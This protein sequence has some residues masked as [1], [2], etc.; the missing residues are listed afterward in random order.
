MAT[1]APHPTDDLNV[2]PKVTEV[3]FSIRISHPQR[4][5][6]QIKAELTQTA[7]SWLRS[8]EQRAELSSIFLTMLNRRYRLRQG[9]KVYL[10]NYRESNGSLLISFSVLIIGF[11]SNYGGLQDSIERFAAD[12]D[13]FFDYMGPDYE[14]IIEHTRIT[15]FQDDTNGVIVRDD[16]FRNLEDRYS[17]SDLSKQVK[18]VRTLVVIMALLLLAV[19]TALT[20]FLT[21]QG[22]ALKADNVKTIIRDEIERN[23][24]KSKLDLIYYQNS[25]VQPKQPIDVESVRS[26]NRGADS[27]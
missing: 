8:D 21:S 25:V 5:F 16:N 14:V 10:A 20:G 24:E 1:T 27:K 11:I 4:N 22:E 12:V 23:T 9:E 13:H 19:G 2:T 18:T 15:P 3:E 7:S 26:T 6:S 17:L